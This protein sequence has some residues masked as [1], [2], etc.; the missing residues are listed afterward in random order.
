MPSISKGTTTDAE[1]EE[2]IPAGWRRPLTDDYEAATLPDVRVA[3]VFEAVQKPLPLTCFTLAA[4]ALIYTLLLSSSMGFGWLAVVAC[5]ALTAAG[6]VAVAGSFEQTR[7]ETEHSLRTRWEADRLQR[8]R[9]SLDALKDTLVLDF[10]GSDMRDGRRALDQLSRAFHELEP[11]LV[12][13]EADPLLLALMPR[14]SVEL[15]REGL[16][17]L[18]DARSRGSARFS[19]ESAELRKQI[20]EYA[21]EIEALKD[22]PLQAE[23]VRL[24]QDYMD[25]DMRSLEILQANQLKFGRLVL[26]AMGCGVQLQQTR[27]DLLALRSGASTAGAEALIEAM[28]RTLEQAKQVQA[29]I[30][31]LG[32]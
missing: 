27:S 14:L 32:F 11:A 8:Q 2:P 12:R 13:R 22:D 16:H 20:D 25:S 17:A 21:A 19:E 7:M 15:Y 24:K 1:A 3:A 26:Q 23:S 28:Q 30:R 29:E 4:L 31:K 5:L 18:S 6:V 9:Q 10:E